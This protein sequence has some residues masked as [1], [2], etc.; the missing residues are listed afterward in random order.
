MM[1]Q[2]SDPCPISS[3]FCRSSNFFHA[4]ILTV[5]WRLTASYFMNR[6]NS[7]KYLTHIHTTLW[8][9]Y[10]VVITVGMEIWWLGSTLSYHPTGKW[11]SLH[12]LLLSSL[13]F[14]QYDMW[15][16]SNQDS[17]SEV[18]TTASLLCSGDIHKFVTVFRQQL[19][20]YWIGSIHLLIP[21]GFWHRCGSHCSK[22]IVVDEDGL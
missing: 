21:N 14:Y 22:S 11:R 7:M 1:R 3:E 15:W 2:K 18:V 5:M 16:D 10:M 4:L 8:Y 12:H 19:Y 17:N 9:R 6:A 20:F 13:Y